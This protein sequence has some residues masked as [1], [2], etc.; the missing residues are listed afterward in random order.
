MLLHAPFINTHLHTSCSPDG[1]NTPQ[2]MAEQARACGLRTVAF[3]D[4]CE[5]EK[6][7][8][9][10]YYRSV[11]EAYRQAD[12]LRKTCRAPEILVGIEIGQPRSNL[13]LCEQLLSKFAYDYVLVS[14]HRLP[15]TME[16]YHLGATVDGAVYLLRNYY[17]ELERIITWGQFDALAHVTYPM[18][19]IH[20]LHK[21]DIPREAYQPALD[22]VLRAAAQAGKAIEVNTQEGYVL[23]DREALERFRA[24]GG[25]HV[26][27]GSDAH[28]ADAIMQ[29][30]AAG[31]QLIYDSG[32]RC[33]TVYR[34]RKPYEIPL[35]E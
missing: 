19:F 23:P 1:Q 15:D 28:S 35:S 6:Y 11:P 27:L 20:A 30:L 17:A 34:Q 13:P 10:A 16:Y 26:T 5:T 12:A 3:T 2:E 25:R 22:R 33:I 21:L 14:L 9:A 31:Q 29:G 18:R 4:H 7:F 8:T 32:F 24:F